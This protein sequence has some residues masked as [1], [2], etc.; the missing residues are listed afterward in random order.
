LAAVKIVEATKNLV[1]L[2]QS[3]LRDKINKIDIESI[4]EVGDNSIGVVDFAESAARKGGRVVV[5]AGV[6]EQLDESKRREAGLGP[7]LVSQSTPLSWLMT[8]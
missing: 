8:S 1:G 5:R 3:E 4:K 2:G 6:S 7:M